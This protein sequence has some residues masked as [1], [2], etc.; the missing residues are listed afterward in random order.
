MRILF[1]NRFFYPDHSA[2]SQMLS[3]LAF[4][5]ARRGHD[6]SVVTSRQRYDDANAM[7]TAFEDIHG[8]H[9]H[10]VWTSR[11]G[12][13]NLLG[14]AIDYLSFYAAAFLCL[15]RILEKGDV[16]VSK[17]DPPLI[18]VVAALA[19]RIKGARLV[20]W[21]QDVF[22]EVGRALGV[23]I[24]MG[25]LGRWSM[26]ARDAS[27]RQAA[28]SVALGDLMAALVIGRNIA[29][30]QV[31]TIHNWADDQAIVPIPQEA[32]SL[33]REWGLN[34]KFVVAYSGNL[35]RAHE[36][37]T[38]LDAARMLDGNDDIAFLFIGAGAQFKVVDAYVTKH[39]L[40]NV[41]MR[42]YQPREKLALSLGAG[43]LHLVSLT[44]ALEGLIVPS[45]FYGIAA[46]GRATAFVG[47]ANGEI[48]RIVARYDCGLS[49]SI[50][51]A[52]GLA[53]FIARMANDRAECMR[54]GQNARTAVDAEFSQTK[55]LQH[56]D[57]VL[58]R[59]SERQ[60]A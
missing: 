11:F 8:V 28:V 46:A 47:D 6:V 57:H 58:N 7:L 39:G 30:E 48:G 41:T 37:G 40:R 45:K 18:S 44:P 1:V 53:R 10:R 16:L 60:G 3:D 9:V 15:L 20:N 36:F 43:D 33:R 31:V 24:L 26:T 55:A 59:V 17:T 23:K 49:F 38:I 4:F 35:G 21:L 34:R 54:L 52:E 50:G 27:L 22:P 25:A 51:D 12:R 14:R 29:S 32:N 2:T 42:P 56:W 19:A 5:L 13:G